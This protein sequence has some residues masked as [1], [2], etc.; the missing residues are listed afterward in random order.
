MGSQEVWNFLADRYNSLW[1]QQVSL[2]PTRRLVCSLTEKL[3]SRS[4]I[5]ILDM[6]CGTGQQYGD[7]VSQFGSDRF[8]YTGVDRSGEM[9]RHAKRSYPEAVFLINDACRF[10]A[11]SGSFDLIICSHSFP[12]YENGEDVLKRFFSLLKPGGV[13]L[14]SQACINTLYDRLA[15]KGVSMTTSKARYRSCSTMEKLGGFFNDL[16]IIRITTRWFMPS[17]YLFRWKK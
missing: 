9:V 2:K 8:L 4:P 13:L 17:L 6:G 7:L 12:Y 5:K 11:Q 15:L 10:S 16:E 3:L 14:L 1:V